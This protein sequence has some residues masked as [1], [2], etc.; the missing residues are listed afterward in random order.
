M[1]VNVLSEENFESEVLKW[2]WVYLVDFWAE[3]C[4][5]CQMMLPILWDFAWEVVW[6]VNVGKVNVD[7][8]PAIAQSFRVMSIPTLLVFKDGKVVENMVWVKQK[9][10][11]IEICS[12]YL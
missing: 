9:S 6:K 5:P 10:E 4:G 7:E 12:K 1:S 2:T 11:L 8:N 3:W